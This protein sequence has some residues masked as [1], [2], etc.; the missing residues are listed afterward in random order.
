MLGRILAPGTGT[1]TSDEKP[2]RTPRSL[3]AS[4]S[5]TD[6]ADRIQGAHHEHGQEPEQVSRQDVGH[7]GAPLTGHPPL[8]LPAETSVGG[9]RGVIC[10]RDIRE[11]LDKVIVYNKLVR[12]RLPEIIVASGKRCETLVLEPVEYRRH[13][14]MKLREELAEYEESGAMEELVDVIEII[15]A[16]AEDAGLSPEQLE[17]MRLGKVE[18]RGAFRKRLLLISVSE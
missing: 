15:C 8:M 16:L 1:E 2:H 3:P 18:A 6:N 17:A 10:L 4:L 11:G 13:L 7:T 5:A 9:L 14:Q 12:D